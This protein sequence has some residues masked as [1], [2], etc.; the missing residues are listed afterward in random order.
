MKICAACFVGIVLAGCVS[1]PPRE[2][3][4]WV[5]TDGQKGSE[6]PA[7]AQQ[8]EIDKTVCLGETQKTAVGMAPI[9]YQGVAGAI[10]ANRI[11]AQRGEALEQVIQ[12]C[13]AQKGYVYV[14]KSQAEETAKRFRASAGARANA[15][16]K[17]IR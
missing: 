10:E 14:P 12:G 9:Y 16:A 17:R 5:R 15:E 6:V 11:E 3:R 7:L 13:M 8:F 2:E 1:T 4:V